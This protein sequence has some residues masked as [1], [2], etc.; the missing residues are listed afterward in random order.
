MTHEDMEN[1]LKLYATLNNDDNPTFTDTIKN[2]EKTLLMANF[3]TKAIE[4]FNKTYA[5]ND[6]RIID[7]PVVI[8]LESIVEKAG[9]VEP[10]LNKL[11]TLLD[12]HQISTK[13]GEIA[14]DINPSNVKKKPEL[15][16]DFQ[17]LCKRA[18]DNEYTKTLINDNALANVKL[19][20]E[21]PEKYGGYILQLSNKLVGAKIKEDKLNMIDESFKK[22]SKLTSD[23]IDKITNISEPLAV[24]EQKLKDILFA[25]DPVLCKFT[26]SNIITQ[27]A[28]AKRKSIIPGR[29]SLIKMV[30]L[31]VHED[32]SKGV[33]IGK[34]NKMLK[35]KLEAYETAVLAKYFSSPKLSA[36]ISTSILQGD[37]LNEL[38]KALSMCIEKSGKGGI[39][40]NQDKVLN[41][42]FEKLSSS[43]QSQKPEQPRN[44]NKS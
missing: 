25:K 21:K 42:L 17:K 2:L 35:D 11:K 23:N 4:D 14:V 9:M 7:D 27:F 16:S 5:P 40:A 1:L 8:A 36:D 13:L 3:A 43:S 19:A 41:E 29:Q 31:T 44:S 28:K 10:F 24:E 12:A 33:E 30:G 18:N 26:S 32:I 15:L 6:S 37:Q 34:L 38:K 39:L 22:L 20:I